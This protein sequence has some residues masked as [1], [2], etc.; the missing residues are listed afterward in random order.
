MLQNMLDFD[1]TSE[2][3]LDLTRDILGQDTA[4]RFKA[5]GISMRPWILDGDLLEVRSVLPQTLHVGDVVLF[6][7]AKNYLL[8]HR[9]LKVTQKNAKRYFFI[10]GDAVREAD[11]WIPEDLILGKVVLFERNGKIHRLDGLISRFLAFL[12][13]KI[14]STLKKIYTFFKK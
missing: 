11:G 6:N 3:F 9:I 5:R 1:L 10:Q 12:L 13:V 7:P 2:Q 4:V 14:L 8:V